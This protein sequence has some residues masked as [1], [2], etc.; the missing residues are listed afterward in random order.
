MGV[1]IAKICVYLPGGKT[2]ICLIG[3]QAICRRCL[4]CCL[5]LQKTINQPD[6]TL[7]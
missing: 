6:L 1:H 5:G 7:G 4:F 3:Q 2:Q